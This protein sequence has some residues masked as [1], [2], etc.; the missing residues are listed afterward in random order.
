MTNA[1]PQMRHIDET[2][3]RC[4]LEA[5]R[6]SDL[7]GV[8]EALEG[9]ASFHIALGRRNAYGRYSVGTPWT[10]VGTA[11]H[12]TAVKADQLHRSAEGVLATC[13]HE[14]TLAVAGAAGVRDVSRQGRWHH[15]TFCRLAVAIG[16]YVVWVPGVGHRTVG[17]T[18]DGR[19]R[20][21]DLLDGLDPEGLTRVPVTQ[22]TPRKTGASCASAAM[23]S[24]GLYVLLSFGCLAP[25]G[26][27]VPLPMLRSAWPRVQ[28]LEYMPD[29]RLQPAPSDI[30]LSTQ[31]PT[32]PTMADP[33][34][35]YR[36]DLS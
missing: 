13:L 20:F 2:L 27:P 12:E 33:R 4:A 24:G 8:S 5:S 15:A 7:P 28:C 19:D 36:K 22:P 18:S 21:G 35:A 34:Q 32:T 29:L 11:R 9:V 17:Q 3:P 14:T 1:T 16:C 23:A 6:R 26:R 25:Q 10:Q 31:P 30:P